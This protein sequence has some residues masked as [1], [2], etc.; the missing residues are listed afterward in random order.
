MR[1][2]ILKLCLRKILYI[3][4]YILI[5]KLLLEYKC[6]DYNIFCLFYGIF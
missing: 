1:Y 5:C 6:L 3:V 4:F 2:D